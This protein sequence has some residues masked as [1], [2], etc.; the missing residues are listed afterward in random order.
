MSGTVAPQVTLLMGTSTKPTVPHISEG[1][2]VFMKCQ[3]N[4]N[5]HTY[6]IQFFFNGTQIVDNSD[7]VFIN[8]SSLVIKSVRRHHSGRY[9]CFA[10]NSEGRGDSNELSIFVTY[11]PVCQTHKR[12]FGAALGEKVKIQCRV[13]AEPPDVAFQWTV[14]NNEL[15]GSFQ[16]FGLESTLT[17][18]PKTKRDFGVVACRA[19]NG[20][21]VQRDPCVFSVVAAGIPSPVTGCLVVNQTSSSILIDCISGDDGGLEQAF[22]LELYEGY[23]QRR[24]VSNHSQ[25]H[26]AEF[27]LTGLSS[28]TQYLAVIYASNGK[29]RSAPI[30]L[31]VPTLA[32]LNRKFVADSP[33]TD[34]ISI[35]LAA[36]LGMGLAKGVVGK[37]LQRPAIEC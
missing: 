25:K 33:H 7:G 29:G 3:I 2:E 12:V 16:S 30:E 13:G 19:K 35:V 28:G 37:A 18:V 17:F 21:G 14:N 27:K 32:L 1:D 8:N 10:N 26:R 34:D 23:G 15:L 24:M 20:A 36:A 4:A 5:P 31:T 9:Q 6:V 11:A 22:H